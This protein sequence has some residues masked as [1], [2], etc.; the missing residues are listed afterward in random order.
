M[1][2]RRAL[3]ALALVALG[4]PASAA[5][6]RRQP[7]PAPAPAPAA[8][9][10]PGP[11]SVAV[12][13]TEAW[14]HVFHTRLVIPAA[15]G[16]MTL[17]YPQWLPGEHG[18]T[19]PI[20]QMAGLHIT[21]GGATVPWRRD[22]RDNY[23]FLIDVPAGATSIEVAFDYLSP[24]ATSGFTGAASAS[25]N[26][27]VLSWNTVVLYPA[28]Y[29]SDDLR[30]NASVRWPAGWKSGTALP[31]AGSSGDA[32]TFDTVSLTTL[33][34][35]PVLAGRYFRV[36]R[37]TSGGDLPP[38]EIDVAAESEGELA[39]SAEREAGLRRLVSEANALF[40]AHHYPKYHFLVTL[41]DQVSHF[42]LEHH[43]SSDDR[44]S[45]RSF[46][47][48]DQWLG[49]SGLLP[50]EFVHSWNGKYRRPAGLAT[51]DYQKPMED[52]LLWVYEG[53]TEYLGYVLTARSG[54]Q[55]PDEF[56]DDLARVAALLDRKSGRTWRPLQDTA[57]MAAQLYNAPGEWSN[58]RRGVDF[59]DEGV[60]L[61][62]EVDT[63]IRKETNGAKSIEDF[64]RIFHGPPSTGPMVKPYTFDDVVSALNQ[65]AP[66]DWRAFLRSRLDATEPHAA[67]GGIE[68]GGWRL[69][70]ND[71]PN[72][73]MKAGESVDKGLDLTY[74]GGLAVGEDGKVFDV[75]KGGPADR[76]GVSPGMVVIA[77]NG[78]KF[79][80]DAMR[81]AL[82]SAKASNRPVD[83]I[84][85]NGDY[86]RTA[87]L[88]YRGGLLYPHLERDS[89][90]P[91]VLGQ[92]MQP[93]KP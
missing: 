30:Y 13:A 47:D 16:P 65:V 5:P 77:V 74:S 86:F 52:D 68:A 70:Y 20:L 39:L 72:L 91:D 44:T 42:G 62:L 92:I 79:T 87:T 28:G 38:H 53:L 31:A 41:S 17:L 6:Q 8:R 89:S 76:A 60:L 59:Y 50:H 19:G 12:D 26:L 80:D 84:V 49:F 21:A 4:A 7:K 64:C 10:A 29:P 90:K 18:P 66:R 75:V 35:S 63:I 43:E 27:S 45:E 54:L 14:R 71:T 73:V 34:D 78:R 15:P 3:I 58:Y 2:S 83:L 88:D 37:L 40:G 55:S 22:V 48:D 61:W 69:V 25:E 1:I 36:I 93:L 23:T 81:E 85:Q 24:G 51:G 56:H 67:M 11:I 57:T 9:P 33:V 32:T 82:A 46:L